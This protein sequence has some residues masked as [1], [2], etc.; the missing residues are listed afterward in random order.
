MN[1]VKAII[2]AG[3]IG[4][5]MWPIKASKAVL[6][7]FGTPLILHTL[8]TV[9]KAGVDDFVVVA[10]PEIAGQLRKLTAPFKAQIVLQPNPR[11]L[12]DAVTQ[13]LKGDSLLRGVR[14]VKEKQPI[15]VV[16]ANDLFAPELIKQIIRH[17][18]KEESE[19]ILPGLRVK[20]Y[21]PGGYLE[22]KK[23]RL[24]RI[25]EKPPFGKEPSHWVKLVVDYFKNSQPLLKIL[26]QNQAQFDVY[27]IAL[28]QMIKSKS[29]VA[30]VKYQ[31]YWGSIKYPWD[32]LK[33]MAL[34]FKFR[35]PQKKG[36]KPDVSRSVTIT[37]PVI[38][39]EGVRLLEGAKV[40][41]PAYIGAGTIIGNHSLVRES[42]IGANCV[43]GYGT[44]IARSYVGNNG[45][46][47]SNYVGDS[48]LGNNVSLGAGAVLANLRFDEDKVSSLVDGDKVDTGLDK[49]GAMIGDNVKIG[50]NASLMPGIKVG[51]HS[52]VGPGVVL[53]RDLAE[54]K[55]CQLKQKL[56]LRKNKKIIGDQV[57]EK[58]RKKI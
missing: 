16:N 49:L 33:A 50:V 44:E 54:N 19:V 3:G 43:V 18:Q 26:A 30:V 34:F 20:E 39:E 56:A 1:Q 23:G 2:L 55:F 48:V 37:G 6:P 32:V 21:F 47:H 40:R 11:G 25:I 14:Q 29:R 45:W 57:R 27:E 58:A 42:M 31:N 38:F 7:F 17:A 5:R 24:T 13:G 46:F 28:N 51:S 41:G 9:K 12:S 15:L 53:E 22:F 52:L 4:Q 10:R 35:F 36:K 8:E